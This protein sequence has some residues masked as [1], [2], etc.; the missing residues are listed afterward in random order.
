MKLLRRLF[1]YSLLFSILYL[2][3]AEIDVLSR[4]TLIVVLIPVVPLL[5]LLLKKLFRL[6]LGKYFFGSQKKW[7]K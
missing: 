7:H 5:D 1:D 3:G 4:W 6:S 2:I